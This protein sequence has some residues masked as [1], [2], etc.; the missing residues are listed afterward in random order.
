MSS[1]RSLEFQEGVLLLLDQRRLPGEEVYVSCRDYR[2]VGEAIRSM[3]VRGAPAIGVAAA[4]GMALAARETSGQP[5]GALLRHLEEAARFL[6]GTRP[7]A[8]NLSWAVHRLLRVARD[9]LGS[10]EGARGIS[11]RLL[12]EAHRIR[13]EDIAINW[14]IGELGASLLSAGSRVLTHCN[15]GALATAGYGTAGGVIRSAFRQGRLSLVYVDETRPFLQGSRLTAWELKKEG[16][17][18]LLITDSAAGYCMRRGDIDAV[19]VGADRIARNGDVANKIGT[20]TVALLAREHGLPFYVAA[21]LSSIDFSLQSGEEIPIEERAPEE[22]THL[23]GRPICPEGVGAFN[24]AF[25]ITPASLVEALITER[26]IL[27]PKL[28]ETPEVW[29]S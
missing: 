25:D 14:R 18:V 10:R 20:Y 8:V 17:P 9:G 5:P 28:G 23:G 12:S 3:V 6:K 26:G 7:T 2:E 21:P 4:Y 27:R 16:I 15:A 24:P 19:I 13:E 1:V 29:Q 22:V 11:D